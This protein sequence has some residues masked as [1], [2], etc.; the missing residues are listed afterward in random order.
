MTRYADVPFDGMPEPTPAWV[1]PS[2]SVRLPAQV[3]D[4]QLAAALPHCGVEEVDL[5][6]VLLEVADGLL[7]TAATDRYTMLRER[8]P[9]SQDCE[10]F[11]FLLRDGDAKSLRVLLK[12]VMRGLDPEDKAN[13]PVDLALEQ[14]DDGPTLRVLG[15]DLDVRFTEHQ[16]A[17][18]LA[19]YPDLDQMLRNVLE[20][21]ADRRY[22]PF[23]TTLNPQHLQRVAALQSAGRSQSLFLFRAAARLGD[24]QPEDQRN[25][26][27]VVT[28]A[29]EDDDVVIVLMPLARTE[30]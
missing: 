27:V 26:P 29:D 10:D 19:P 17:K 5:D 23:D 24:E 12:G 4:W 16:Q 6:V 2:Q 7:T 1:R 21:L 3:L 9:I 30:P 11:R 28:T 13:E 20:R 8:Q 25:S 15:R 14:T 18:S 22:Q